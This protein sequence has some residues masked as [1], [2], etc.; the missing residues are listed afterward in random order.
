M[1]NIFKKSDLP[2]IDKA[3]HNKDALDEQVG[4]YYKIRVEDGFVRHIATEVILLERAAMMGNGYA[5]WELAQH[6]FYD[7][8]VRNLPLS[9]HWWKKAIVMGN[10]AA[11][12]R[13][14]EL[15]E[16]LISAIADYKEGFGEYADLE[17]RLAMLT[18][19]YLF[20]LGSLSW[21]S[22]SDS[23]RIE[24]INKLAY[25]S[26]P[27]LDAPF[28]GISATPGLTFTENGRT[29]T[30][31]GLAHPDRR[32][33]T[34]RSEM[35]VNIERVIAVLFHELGH[36]VCFRA[37]GDYEYAKKWGLTPE[38]IAS[39]HSGAMGYEVK[40]SEE[41]P[42]SLSYGVYTHW[43]ILFDERK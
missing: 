25:A 26:A 3:V 5:I 37:M 32:A 2:L 31:D 15:R 13:Y 12:Q 40:T 23:E 18:E 24:R 33:I 21:Q 9:L 27:L 38:R 19:I 42:D 16:Y 1:K 39:W 17:L 22:L 35:M 4:L 14:T 7:E 28:S 6:Y 11:K 36:L 30:V 29:Y 20:E 8:A 43:A 41:D 34:L 10:A